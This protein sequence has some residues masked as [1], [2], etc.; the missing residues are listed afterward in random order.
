MP[1]MLLSSYRLREKVGRGC[2]DEL[3]SCSESNRMKI[4]VTGSSPFITVKGSSFPLDCGIRQ[5]GQRR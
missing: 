2:S 5:I 1:A 3:G 4:L